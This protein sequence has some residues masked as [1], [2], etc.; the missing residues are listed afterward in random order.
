MNYIVAWS[1]KHDIIENLIID[2]WMPFL[3]D[4]GATLDKAKEYYQKLIDNDG[5]KK[6]WHLYTITLSTLLESTDYS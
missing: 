3:H 2:Y 6:G 4:E 1:L 5:N